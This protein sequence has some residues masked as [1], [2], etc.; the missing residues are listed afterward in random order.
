MM[1]KEA[2][3]PSISPS[4]FSCHGLNALRQ[5]VEVLAA[6]PAD[7]REVPRGFLAKCQ[8]AAAGTIGNAVLPGERLEIILFDV[9]LSADILPT[10]TLQQVEAGE[11]PCLNFFPSVHGKKGPAST[12][13][14]GLDINEPRTPTSIT[15]AV[16]TQDKEIRHAFILLH[17]LQNTFDF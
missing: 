15:V 7:C 14:L 2:S 3:T 8:A 11:R 17:N 9:D 1:S 13:E 5:C 10:P 6:L 4:L 12:Y 16:Y